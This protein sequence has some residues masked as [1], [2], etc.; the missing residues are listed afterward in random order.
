MIDR[1]KMSKSVALLKTLFILIVAFFTA[2][3]PV[4]SAMSFDI[5]IDTGAIHF[6]GEIADFYFVATYGD[7]GRVDAYITKA[8]LYYEGEH[9]KDLTPYVERIDIGFFWVKYLIPTDAPT[10]IYTLL[11]DAKY[12]VDTTEIKTATL[13]SFLLSP[14]LADLN[15]RILAIQGDIAIVTTDVGVIKASLNAIE[16]TITSIE[17]SIATIETNLG[18]VQSSLSGLNAKIVSLSG[19]VATIKTDIGTIE[20]KIDDVNAEVVAIEGLTATINTD[21]DTIKGKITSIEGDIATIKTDIGTIKMLLNI[22]TVTFSTTLDSYDIPISTTSTLEKPMV[23]SEN[24]LTVVVSGPSGT[25][26]TVN[27]VIPK[28]LL[29]DLEATIDDVIATVNDKQ[30]P[31]IYIEQPETYVLSVTFTHSI[32][33]IKIFLAGSPSPSP[34]EPWLPYIIVAIAIVAILAIAALVIKKRVNKKQTK[35]S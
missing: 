14:T 25:V 22:T 33:T 15:A 26:G 13:K 8:M 6:R 29:I 2:I 20:A 17:G 27:V 28:Q 21:I 9:V 18:T 12:L 11:V 19:D 30:A 16:A 3:Q 32:R 4:A 31:F 7:A 35:P 34:I 1:K 5:E 24:T 23:I 10:G